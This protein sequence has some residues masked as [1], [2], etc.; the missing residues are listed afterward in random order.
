MVLSTVVFASPFD[1]V[2]D[3]AS[4]AEAVTTLSSLGLFKGDDQ[5]NFNPDKTITRAEF[6]AVIVRTMGMGDPGPTATVFTDVPATHW[7]SGYIQAAT[8][9]GILAGYGDGNFGPDDPVTYEQAVKMI[10]AALGYTPEADNRGRYPTGYMLI[11]A[12][13]GITTGAN[14]KVGEQ[15]VRATVAQLLYNALD[16]PLMVQTGFGSQISYEVMDGR[17]GRDFK[18]ILSEKLDVTKIEGIV[19]ENKLIDDIGVADS[20]KEVIIRIEEIND[21]RYDYYNQNIESISRE[22]RIRIGETNAKDYLGYT[23]AAYVKEFDTSDQYLVSISPKAGENQVIVI[24]DMENVETIA[25]NTDEIIDNSGNTRIFRYWLDK[26]NDSDAEEIE[27]SD[28]YRYFRN[29]VEKDKGSNKNPTKPESGKIVLLDNNDDDK[30]DFIFVTSYEYYVVDEV[31][32]GNV[33]GKNDSIYFDDNDKNL[34]YAIYLDGEKISWKDLQEW[35]VLSVVKATNNTN[36]KKYYT[37][38]VTRD[39][40]T[41]IVTEDLSEKEGSKVVAEKYVIDGKEVSLVSNWGSTGTSTIKLGSEYTFYLNVDGKV[42]HVERGAVVGKT[43]ENYAYLFNAARSTGLSNGFE[44]ELFTADGKWVVYE[45]ADKFYINDD[46]NTRVDA[47]TWNEVPGLIEFKNGSF[48]KEKCRQLVTYKLDAS[49]KIREIYGSKLTKKLIDNASSIDQKDEYRNEYVDQYDNDTSAE[50]RKSLNRLSKYYITDSTVIFAINK[51]KE[52]DKDSYQIVT[53]SA[54]TDGK[55]YNVEFYDVESGNEPLAIVA[56]NVSGTITEDAG[57]FVVRSVSEARNDDDEIV[58]VFRGANNETI[59]VS[60]DV[61]VTK[62]V[63]SGNVLVD[64][65]YNVKPNAM[66]D[67]VIQYSLN[68]NDEVDNI[69]V[70]FA[71]NIYTDGFSGYVEDDRSDLKIAF[72]KVTSKS[73]SRLTLVNKEGKEVD[74]IPMSGANYV[75]LDLRYSTTR[76]R[77]NVGSGDILINESFALVREY[78]DRERDIVI[79]QGIGY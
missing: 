12:R 73:R 70:L 31:D 75:E 32:N 8:Q 29:G 71:K 41:G 69:R 55:K 20:K 35:D 16:V 1:D 54:F 45:T 66:K 28:N 6:A 36:T 27:I 2:S 18:T 9:M 58:Y 25:D 53:S 44:L 14:G 5:G 47:N 30:Y 22:Q 67:Y 3:D 57:V 46:Q 26:D 38:Y 68:S 74:S 23:V 15:A 62:L 60:E 11:A 7:G 17:N 39:S 51:D 65:K 52:D 10:V 13:E 59:T 64:E 21:M 56:Y 48:D 43:P 79:I 34:E 77:T 40:I 63:Q 76:I 42:V 24:T 19:I 50:Y 49:G 37:V 78:E 33:T 4:Y 72:G 61:Y